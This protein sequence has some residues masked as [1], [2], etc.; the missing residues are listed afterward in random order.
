MPRVR[1]YAGGT[2]IFDPVQVSG[3]GKPNVAGQQSQPQQS[4]PEQSGQLQS[5]LHQASIGLPLNGP[6]YGSRQ[7]YWHVP[8]W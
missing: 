6:G 1:R 4:Q 5:Q 2:T 7:Q 3:P 8:H